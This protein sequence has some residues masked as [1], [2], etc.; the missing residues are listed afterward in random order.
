MDWKFFFRYPKCIFDSADKEKIWTT[1][2]P[3]F[4]GEDS[5]KQAI[6]VRAF[7]MVCAD[8]ERLSETILPN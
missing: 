3:E 6:I 4:G 8:Q 7:S 2:G 1:C 5:G